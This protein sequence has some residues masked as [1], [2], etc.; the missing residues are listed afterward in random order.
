MRVRVCVCRGVPSD[1]TVYIYIYLEREREIE[2]ETHTHKKNLI[3]S[4]RI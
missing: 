2:R 3:V 4:T 1:E